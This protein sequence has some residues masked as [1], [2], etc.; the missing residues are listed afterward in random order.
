MHVL[1]ARAAPGP[2][3]TAPLTWVAAARTGKSADVRDFLLYR[4]PPGQGQ[5][6]V[7]VLDIAS[8]HRSQEMQQA[9]PQLQ[10][11]GI[12]LYLLSPYSPEL[13]DIEPYFGRV[14]HQEMP[15]RSYTS[16]R[17]MIKAIHAAF[18]RVETDLLTRQNS[19]PTAKVMP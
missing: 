2:T 4:L 14:K 17:T 12:E 10:D 16:T 19:M 8:C 5:P 3:Y 6:R 9:Q 15:I 7:V 1:A 11:E 13:H 18:R